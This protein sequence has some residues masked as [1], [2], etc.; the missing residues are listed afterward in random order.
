MNTHQIYSLGI[1]Q[2]SQTSGTSGGFQQTVLMS[3]REAYRANLQ[4]SQGS[5][6][7]VATRD[8]YGTMAS[9]FVASYDPGSQC[10]RTLQASLR[11]TEEQPLTESLRDFTR[12]GLMYG[13]K[14]YQLAPLVRITREIASSL[15]PT[16]TVTGNHN[17]SDREPQLQRGER[18]ERG[19]D[20]SGTKEKEPNTTTETD[21]PG[22]NGGPWYLLEESE[23][24]KPQIQ[25]GGLPRHALASRWLPTG[26]WFE[27]EPRLVRLVHGFPD[28]AHRLAALGNAIVPQVVYPLAKEI[29]RILRP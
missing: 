23:K 7:E 6:V 25:S 27:C 3:L 15:L 16:I 19:R 18:D 12:S 2:Q 29:Y 8:G 21:S 20:N 4:A 26:D 17:Y 24:R 1:G 9:S 14:L 13:G 11:L 22:I 28:R 5:A 10:L